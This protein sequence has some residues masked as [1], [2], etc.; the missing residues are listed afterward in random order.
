MLAL[1][2]FAQFFAHRFQR[3]LDQGPAIE[4]H[5]GRQLKGVRH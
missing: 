4:R 1:V 5:K 3:R 2:G